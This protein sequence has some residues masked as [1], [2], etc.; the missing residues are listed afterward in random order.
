MIPQNDFAHA[1]YD[2]GEWE[3]AKY[4]SF[5]DKAGQDMIVEVKN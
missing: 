3:L 1:D 5:S 2:T 4:S